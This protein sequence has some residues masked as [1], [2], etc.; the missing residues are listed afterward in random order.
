MDETEILNNTEINIS[1]ITE[2]KKAEEALRETTSYLE[3]LFNYANAPIIAWDPSF[4]ITRFN[5]A[6]EGLAGYTAKEIIGQRLAILFPKASKDKS[7]AKVEHTLKGEY[8]KTVEI[9]ILCKDRSI[10]TVLWNSANIYEEDGKTL[11]ATIAQGIDITERKKAEG[12]IKNL[13]KFPSENPHP[14]LRV[15]KDGKV[16]YSNKA[17]FAVLDKWKS[18]VG[19]KVPK[20]WKQIITEMFTSKSL[21]EEEEEE[22][23][24]E[25]NGKTFSF[26]VAP[27]A[28]TGY[29]NLYG[30]DITER[31]KAEKTLKKSEE[32]L[33]H[34]D[35]IAL[36][37]KNLA[38][39]ELIEHMERTK[40][41]TKEDITINVDEL[42]MP[43]LKKLQLKG[44]SPKYTTLLR[45]GLEDLTSSFGRKITER[46]AK[47]SPRE[48]EICSIIKG[49][50]PSKEISELLKVSYQT[51]DKHRRNIRKK[52]GIS[53]KKV[54][55]TSFLQKL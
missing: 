39:K 6:F 54:N 32:G 18:K 45:H 1:E 13:A 7:L 44:A 16:L 31:K 50:L 55:L 38:L 51:V 19:E 47:L 3:N 14:V 35:K 43:I 9:P 52:L 40:N 11:M 12:E 20:R 4:K 46:S 21:Q 10:R 5:H 34:E 8:W 24:E 17:G 26:V 25:V 33:L 2:R 29:V 15:T 36:E 22:E 23:E 42:V 49:G 28:D 30:T 37:Q 48:I 27:V 53:K 41:K